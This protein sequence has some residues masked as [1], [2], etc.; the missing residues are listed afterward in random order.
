[1]TPE[2]FAYWLQGFAEMSNQDKISKAQW[3]MIQDHLKTVFKK[4]TPN[5]SPFVATS[6]VMDY[7]MPEGAQNIIC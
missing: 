6:P 7:K 1:M 4:E 3:E 2:Q 5:Y